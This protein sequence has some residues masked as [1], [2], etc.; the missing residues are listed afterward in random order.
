MMTC[1]ESRE[2][3]LE[4]LITSRFYRVGW[5]GDILLNKENVEF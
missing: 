1:T 2:D 3:I 5:A 4:K